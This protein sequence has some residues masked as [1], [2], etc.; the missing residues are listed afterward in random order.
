VNEA[1][2]RSRQEIRN[3]SKGNESG[4]DH[5]KEAQLRSMEQS[6]TEEMDGKRGGGAQQE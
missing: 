6:R 3:T 5:T 1:L 4:D 2:E